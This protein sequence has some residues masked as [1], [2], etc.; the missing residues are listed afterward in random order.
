MPGDLGGHNRSQGPAVPQWR[1]GAKSLSLPGALSSPEVGFA[2]RHLCPG[3]LRGDLGA[4][5]HGWLSFQTLE[6]HLTH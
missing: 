2:A 3:A 1:R 4:R 5:P 6:F